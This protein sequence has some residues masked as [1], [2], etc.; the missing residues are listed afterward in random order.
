MF[1]I[2]LKQGMV[3]SNTGWFNNLN[4]ESGF[5]HF[6][7]A[8]KHMYYYVPERL[9]EVLKIYLTY[10]ADNILIRPG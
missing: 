5:D 9:L 6:M 2:G 10:Q 8:I 4:F 1:K 7:I 3:L